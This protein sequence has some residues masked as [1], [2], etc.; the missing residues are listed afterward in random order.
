MAKIVIAKDKLP[1]LTEAYAD[2]IIT[3]LM[4]V[5]KV[6]MYDKERKGIISSNSKAFRIFFK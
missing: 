6:Q 2:Q 1:M 3:S 4:I 5:I